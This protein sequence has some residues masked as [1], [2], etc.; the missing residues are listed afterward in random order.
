MTL[1]IF[2]SYNNGVEF[3]KMGHVTVNNFKIA[4]NV[5]TEFEIQEANT[6]WGQVQIKVN[7]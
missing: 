4:D 7:I 6:D 5:E 2:T 3:S 1:Y